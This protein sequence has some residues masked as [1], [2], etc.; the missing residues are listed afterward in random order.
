MADLIYW[1]VIMC[2]VAAGGLAA[3]FALRAYTSG[4]SARDM[5]FKPRS[6]PRI[7]VVE[8]ANVDGR[9]R[10]LLIRRDDVEHLIMTGGPVDVLIETGIGEKPSKPSHETQE[11]TVFTRHPR[12]LSATSASDA[13]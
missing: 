4:A 8:Q 7:G 1:V 10:L 5:F 3:V 11:A 9:R 2:V 6:D 12:G 13:S